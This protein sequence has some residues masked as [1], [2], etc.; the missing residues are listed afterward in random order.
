MQIHV[1]PYNIENHNPFKEALSLRIVT[2]A[3]VQTEKGYRVLKGR[4]M[5]L[6]GMQL[7]F[8]YDLKQDLI[9]DLDMISTYFE[10]LDQFQELTALALVTVRQQRTPGAG[11]KK[12]IQ[13]EYLYYAIRASVFQAVL[14]QKGE[15]LLEQVQECD[16]F[17]ACMADMDKHIAE[18]LLKRE[19]L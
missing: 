4:V 15:T 7:R 3:I 16:L 8:L 11:E 17:S 9:P 5:V 12:L 2:Y 19:C 10:S 18:T 6:D 14:T 13:A 1:I